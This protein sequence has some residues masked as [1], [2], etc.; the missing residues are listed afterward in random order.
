MFLPYH[1]ERI[2]PSRFSYGPTESADDETLMKPN[3]TKRRDILLH[4][5]L[6]E[7]P[8]VGYATND[9]LNVHAACFWHFVIDTMRH[10][11]LLVEDYRLLNQDRPR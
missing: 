5:H 10:S 2:L 9:S 3:S 6:I 11:H 8:Y 7:S 1:M 4:R